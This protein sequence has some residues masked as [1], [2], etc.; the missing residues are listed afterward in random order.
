MNNAQAINIGEKSC[1]P[2]DIGMSSAPRG[3]KITKSVAE[4]TK[5]AAATDKAIPIRISA[6][7]VVPVGSTRGRNAVGRHDTQA[8]ATS[9]IQKD[10]I[11]P[12]STA[13]VR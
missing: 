1:M 6:L 3:A 11:H 7:K 12:A 9:G 4:G 2:R 10:A 8:S 13:V 5:N